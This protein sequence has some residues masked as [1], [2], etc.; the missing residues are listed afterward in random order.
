MFSSAFIPKENI[1]INTNLDYSMNKLDEIIENFRCHICHEFPAHP[2]ESV[3][4]GIIYCLNCVPLT[5]YTCSNINCYETEKKSKPF[6]S[7][8]CEKTMK[9]L[10]LSCKHEDCNQTISLNNYTKHLFLCEHKVCECKIGSC[11]FKGKKTDF[12]NHLINN[13][14]KEI[15]IMMENNK[16]IQ[17]IFNILY[18]KVNIN[19]IE[20]YEI[21]N[22]DNLEYELRP[23]KDNYKTDIFDNLYS[24]KNNNKRRPEIINSVSKYIY[25]YYV[26]RI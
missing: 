23:I 18:K 7:V 13:H 25:I 15:L 17:C 4:C 10:T 20:K 2:Y 12:N 26:L 24:K 1:K 22:G 21:N 11:K 14:S 16:E 8:F 5:K 6:F 19:D 9:K 3:C